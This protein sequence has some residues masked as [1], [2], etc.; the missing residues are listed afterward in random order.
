MSQGSS[1]SEGNT[2]NFEIGWRGQ[3]VTWF[4]FDTSLFFVDWDGVVETQVIGPDEVR[5]NSG[6]AHFGG[7]ETSAAVDLI[8]LG[9]KLGRAERPGQYGSLSLFGSLQVLDAKFVD[10][11]RDGLEPAY[12]PDHVIKTGLLYR[13]QDR[14]KLGLVGQFVDEHFWQ[15][16]NTAGSVG[17]AEIASY[18]V[19]DLTAEAKVFRDN[20][21][22]L[23][24]INNLF[25]EDY[26]S[27]IRSDGIEPAS[28]RTFYGG[29]KLKF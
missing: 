16:S 12:A 21:T 14:L 22:V 26:Y 9:E 27:R 25:D 4:Q 28:G 20:V 23:A 13:W 18:S 2:W 11:N 6:R 3:P 15:D 7:W 29:V 17:T 1:P 5:S 8:G 24:G 10:G 19:W